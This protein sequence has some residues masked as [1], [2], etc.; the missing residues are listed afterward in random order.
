M[1]E[2]NSVD[3]LFD[4]V[5]DPVVT[6]EENTDIDESIDNQITT[7]EEP[8]PQPQQPQQGRN[9]VERNPLDFLPQVLKPNQL[10]EGY[11]AATGLIN[12]EIPSI[13]GAENLAVN[14][15]DWVDNT[16][17]GDKRTKEE[18]AEDRREAYTTGHQKKQEAKE[19]IDSNV[20]LEPLRVW[21]GALQGARAKTLS[22][23]EWVGDVVRYAN[24]NVLGHQLYNVAEKDNPFS[25][26]YEWALWNLGQDEIGANTGAGK[27]A[28]GFLEF[29]HILRGAG[30]LRG[31]TGASQKYAAAAVPGQLVSKAQLGVA[32]KTGLVGGLYGMP[33]DF[34]FTLFDEDQGNL[35]NLIK[36]HAPDW[37]PTWLTALAVE[38]DTNPYEAAFLSTLEGFPMGF[39]A[40]AAGAFIGGSRAFKKALKEGA[41]PV[42]AGEIGVKTA[43][44]KLN[45]TSPNAPSTTREIGE[46]EIQN[47]EASLK[48]VQSLESSREILDTIHS[49]ETFDQQRWY[50]KHSGGDGSL[51]TSISIEAQINEF[52]AVGL[53][54]IELP[55][56]SRL[57]FEFR[58]TDSFQDGNLS[59]SQFDIDK[60]KRAIEVS[61]EI[62]EKGIEA[63]GK[64]GRRVITE[65]NKIAQTELAPGTL[66]INY[67]TPDIGL[68]SGAKRA[69][70]LKRKEKIISELGDDLKD[71]YVNEFLGM[72]VFVDSTRQRAV[73][74]ALTSWAEKTTE[75]KYRYAN[76]FKDDGY[77]EDYKWP[78]EPNVRAQIYKRAGFSSLDPVSGA[79]YA[80]VRQAPDASGKFLEAVDING[81]ADARAAQ[82]AA[83]TDSI[84]EGGKGI[85]RLKNDER[86]ARWRVV[87]DQQRKGI[88]VTWDD[89]KAIFPEYFVKGERPIRSNLHPQVFAE[90]QAVLE[91][92]SDGF[93]VNP[94]TGEAPTDGWMVAIDGAVLGEVNED[95]VFDFIMKNAEI[96]SREDAFVGGWLDETGKPVLEISRLIPFNEVPEWANKYSYSPRIEAQTLGYL[97]DQ[98]SIFNTKTFAEDNTQGL[99]LLKETKKQHLGTPPKLEPRTVD[100]TT[101]TAQFL[102]GQEEQIRG[103]K[104]GTQRTI[105]N[106]QI[107]LLSDSTDEGVEN[108]LKSLNASLPIDIKELASVARKT[109]LEIKEQGLLLAQDALGVDGKVDLNKISWKDPEGGLLSAEGII[110]VRR[111]L[112]EVSQSLWESSYQII[113]KGDANMDAFPEVKQLAES[114]KALSRIHKVSAN[115][116]GRFLHT[117]SLKIPF[118]GKEIDNP[119]KPPSIEK[120]AQEI[121]N[122]DKVLDD[123]ISKISKGDP[124]GQREALNIA[125]ALLLA[126]GDP[127]L[128]KALWRHIGEV[129]LGNG[130]KIMY[131]SLLSAPATHL[132]NITSNM[133][134]TVY[135]PVAA[136]T[137]GDIKSRKM[138][139]AGFHGF[140][141]T[142]RDSFNMASRVIKNDGMAINDGSRM[143]LNTKET[144]AKLQ[145]IAKVASETDD[146]GIKAA[147][148][149]A[150][151]LRDIANFPLFAWPTKF[152]VTGDEFFKTMVSRMEYN[153]R[154]ME[155]AINQAGVSG[156][157]LDDVFESLHKANIEQNF[158]LKTGAILNEDLLN[159]AKE[160]TFQTEL[161]GWM[162]T[163][164]D[165]IN[166][167]P[168]LKPFF[169]FVKTGHNI[170]VYSGTHVPILNRFLSEYK[171][172]MEGEDEYAKAVMRGREAYGSLMIISAALAAHNGTITG[173][174]PADPEARRIWLQSHQER[175]IKIGT[176][177]DK[178]G[179]KKTRWLR[180]DRIEPL[181]QILA[182]VVDIYNAFDA[183]NLSEDRARYLAGYLTYAVSAN[184]TKK[185]Y[186]QGIV[187]LGRALTPGWQGL[188][189]LAALPLEVA[190]NFIPLASLRRS[191][192]NA[193]TPYK[194]EFDNSFDRL[195]YTSF[196]INPTANVFNKKSIIAHDW[197]T[198]E[199]IG[200][201][202]GQFNSLFPLKVNSRGASIVH[203]KLEDIEFD[204]NFII[205]SLSG[206]KLDPEHKALLSE[207]MGN[208]GL[209][210]ELEAWVTHPDFDLAVEQYKDKLRSGLR[211]NK[212][213]E[214]FYK[215]I[216]RRIRKYRDDALIEVKARFPELRDEINSQNLLRHQQKTGSSQI[217]A[218]ANF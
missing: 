20:L 100:S 114:W 119:I 15:R 68:E 193:F 188:N 53:R 198:G 44:E 144:E 28:Q 163:T 34:Y 38:D 173:N 12:G 127:S 152:L 35:S 204:S 109:D 174:A 19:A 176:Y 140:Q 179:N 39:G 18:I 87:R 172:V 84:A 62:T 205:K 165:F 159:V 5:E 56:G 157:N 150:H 201:D 122:G 147:S 133:V 138:A 177:T 69:R 29:A 217:E 36:E 125:N 10:Q 108:L 194:L 184:L 13:P 46:A 189:T 57:Q 143:V 67:P 218:L 42:E 181:G 27:V 43:Q 66:L 123:L 85:S 24:Q 73:D 90:I 63:I 33:A 89:I 79:Q 208:S 78:D 192:V 214:Y 187:P 37:Y 111:L 2:F 169:P 45:S 118:T 141:S 9:V 30:G 213:N 126:D 145:L 32:T 6:G 156:T 211:V 124:A 116:Y 168:I 82:I 88:A 195:L 64:H 151:M 110:Q 135:R 185:S 183:G 61:W 210:K 41:S 50:N 134:N 94:F 80:I 51:D 136:F 186:F 40:D 196:G 47:V 55:T 23:I 98:K 31:Y 171:A 117:Y 190:N 203:D 105:T 22:G 207:L 54:E 209:Y 91:G 48:G 106:A 60:Y 142:I 161:D 206:I 99:D 17:Q 72:E 170:M 112:Q 75:Q 153:S 139:I 25:D 102:K 216:V 160:A 83:N 52:G 58:E 175:S 8:Q 162:K 115:Q 14:V 182:P 49:W 26:K 103:A 81:S 95:S 92:T 77:F 130:L 155:E 65:F 1:A 131:N 164:A 3:D 128:I 197:L 154:I 212:R 129:S 16:F 7:E 97:F 104:S 11:D 148:G 70:S 121:R 76:K 202:S 158:D 199:K 132:V 215:E 93:S 74:K 71:L 191:F 86:L 149:T 120:L 137:G 59:R 180:Y 107:R 166:A 21:M 96:L 178:D 113:K 146:K 167:V 101:A 200:N 4:G